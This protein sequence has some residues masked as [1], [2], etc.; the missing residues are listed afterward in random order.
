M[1]KND[2]RRIPIRFSYDNPEHMR[3]LDTLDDLNLD[4]HKSKSHFIMNA[5]AFYMDA[6]ESGNLT[7]AAV[8]KQKEM[9]KE[10]VT[11]DELEERIKQI[12]ESIKTELYQDV[13]KFLGGMMLMPVANRNNIASPSTG[14]DGYERDIGSHVEDDATKKEDDISKT[15]GQYDSVLSQVM[16]WSED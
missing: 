5:I 16:S 8:Q 9:E 12:S 14:H 11:K 1:G 4:V 7:N 6:I 10:F 13:V 2:C 15:L 3:I